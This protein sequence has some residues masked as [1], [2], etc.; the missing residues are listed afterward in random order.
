MGCNHKIVKNLLN[1]GVTM[2]DNKNKVIREEFARAMMIKKAQSVLSESAFRGFIAEMRKYEENAIITENMSSEN[3]Y[4]GFKRQ[5]QEQTSEGEIVANEYG[6][7]EGNVTADAV[8]KPPTGGGGDDGKG[9]KG[10][11]KKSDEVK[12]FM[13]RLSADSKAKLKALRISDPVKAAKYIMKNPDQ[14]EPN[15]EMEADAFVRSETA[16][17]TGKD[18]GSSFDAPE[19]PTGDVKKDTQ[20]LGKELES[21]KA[22]GIL[23]SIFDSYKFAFASNAKMWEKIY[24]FINGIGNKPPAQQAQAAQQAK[25]DLDKNVDTDEEAGRTAEDPDGDEDGDEEGGGD[26]SVNVRK[27]KSSL[28]SRIS[29]LFPDLAKARGTYYYRKTDKQGDQGKIISKNT[30]ALAAIL[31]DIEA[32]LKGSGI[33]ISE[34][35]R[36]ELVDTVGTLFAL[37]TDGILMERN[38]YAKFKTNLQ[39]ALQR[40]TRMHEDPK[41]KRKA[42]QKFLYRLKRYAQD[43]DFSQ[44]AGKKEYQ[45]RTEVP[46]KRGKTQPVNTPIAKLGQ[47]YSEMSPE[48][49]EKAKAKA[50]DYANNQINQQEKRDDPNNPEFK[51][52]TLGN[53]RKDAPTK[54]RHQMA[55]QVPKIKNGVLNIAQIVGPKLKAAGYDLKSPEGQKVQQRLLKVLR[56]FLKKDLE[57]LGLSSKVKLL[58]MFSKS[59]KKGKK[60]KMNE[61]MEMLE[62]SYLDFF[63]NYMLEGIIDELSNQ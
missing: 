29:K 43:G 41:K 16:K 12:K 11:D 2:N 34:S 63:S 14:F 22:K 62:E 35:L 32:Q 54:T 9:D 48:D 33:A 52:T 59:K 61:S 45:G 30:S 55:Q 58:A 57:R 47:L 24:D 44:M 49:Q 27:G 23:S 51:A 37:Q 38:E 6:E 5:L 18:P 21:P 39:V 13:D 15:E 36:A 19:E 26:E 42:I 50:I 56:R 8:K 10:G 7:G 53:A 25:D 1:E 46:D 4:D 40:V 20:N 31:G 3:I 28:Q 17:V 60:G